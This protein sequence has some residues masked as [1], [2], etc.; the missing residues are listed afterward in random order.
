MVRGGSAAPGTSFHC[1]PARGDA[2]PNHRCSPIN[3]PSTEKVK[4]DETSKWLHHAS[5]CEAGKTKGKSPDHPPEGQGSP[6]HLPSPCS[7]RS[8]A[9][10]DAPDPVAHPQLRLARGLLAHPT[11]PSSSGDEAGDGDA[12]PVA[13]KESMEV[14]G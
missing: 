11:S 7:P 13:L 1:E 12:R 3:V 4:H 6:A 5:P 2:D 14:E 10:T 8:E 9:P